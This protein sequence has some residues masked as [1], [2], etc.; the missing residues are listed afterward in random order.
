MGNTGCGL[1][2]IPK[3]GS[4]KRRIKVRVKYYVR[5]E[6]VKT[7]ASASEGSSSLAIKYYPWYTKKLITALMVPGSGWNR[8]WKSKDLK[9]P[10]PG[11]VLSTGPHL[12]RISLR[13]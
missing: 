7:P 4:S 1:G 12:A 9:K 8:S 5:E 10:L 2:F 13:L 6:K 3:G 11:A